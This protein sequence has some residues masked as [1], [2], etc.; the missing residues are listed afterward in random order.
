MRFEQKAQYAT[1][2]RVAY[3]FN[4]LIGGKPITEYQHEGNTFVEGRKGSEFELEFKNHSSKRVLVVPS[5]DGKSIFDKSPATP[6]SRGYVVDA[7]KSIRIPGWTLDQTDVARFV[8]ADKE[9]SYAVVTAEAGE[10]V[11]SGVVGV[12][13]YS[14]VPQPVLRDFDPNMIK[15]P[16]WPSAPAFPYNPAPYWAGTPVNPQV[17]SAADVVQA[18]SRRVMMNSVSASSQSKSATAEPQAATLS[19]SSAADSTPFEMGAGFGQ[20]AEFK[21]HQVQFERDKIE[22]SMVLYYDSRR[23]LE[24]RGIEVVKKEQRHLNE[25]PQ[26]FAGIPGCTPP[27]GWQG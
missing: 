27:E 10:V 18:M 2:P 17:T 21:T 12:L 1:S 20:R 13:V 16:S 5:V 19:A 24:K 14:E 22:A 11:Q 25:L 6:A 8:F 23:N 15:T 7:F 9:K 4:I 26:A 3:E